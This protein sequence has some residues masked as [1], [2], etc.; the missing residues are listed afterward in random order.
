MLTDS[1][2]DP[3]LLVRDGM[4]RD[5]GHVQMAPVDLDLAKAKCLIQIIHWSRVCA[6][7]QAPIRVVCLR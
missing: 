5:F 3:D 7:S 1:E 2:L 6:R 4:A